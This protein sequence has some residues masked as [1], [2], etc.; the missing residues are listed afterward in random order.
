MIL[1]YWHLNKIHRRFSRVYEEPLSYHGYL[2]KEDVGFDI[3]I[4]FDM[5]DENKLKN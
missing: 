5:N 2:V 1:P 4:S 3:H